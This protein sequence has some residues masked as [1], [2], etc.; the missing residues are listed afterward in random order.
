M[1]T[2][3]AVE[4]A[5]PAARLWGAHPPRVLTMAPSLSWTFA[6]RLFRRGAETSTRGRVRSPNADVA[7]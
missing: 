2:Q 5:V 7:I 6:E 3:E 1:G 4:A